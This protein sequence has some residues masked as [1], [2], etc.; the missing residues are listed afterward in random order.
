MEHVGENAANIPNPT[1]IGG[2]FE[3]AICITNRSEW[4]SAEMGRLNQE[5]LEDTKEVR[6]T[7][8]AKVAAA[9]PPTA[10]WHIDYQLHL[11]HQNQ[12]QAL[13]KAH[14]PWKVCYWYQQVF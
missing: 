7:N 4:I 6:A 11:C 8:N 13:S 2:N 3:L 14:E 12:L 9:V 10:P 5:R 1:C